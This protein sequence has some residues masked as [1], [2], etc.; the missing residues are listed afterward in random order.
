MLEPFLTDR[1]LTTLCLLAAPL[2]LVLASSKGGDI[3]PEV[4]ALISELARPKLLIPAF[5]YVAVILIVLIPASRLGAW[6]PSLW[7]ATVTWLLVSGFGLLLGLNEAIE[8]PKFFRHAL[9]RIVGVTA[10]F[11]FIAN[12]ESFPLWTEIPAQVLALL[13]AIIVTTRAELRMASARRVARAYL[14][15]LGL[16]AVVW[17]VWHLVDTWSEL[18]HTL[19]AREFLMPV[20]LTP[21]A[22]LLVYVYAVVAAYELAFI[23]MR[24]AEQEKSLWRQRLGLILRG[25]IWL[26]T[27][28]HIRGDGAGRIARTTGFR[29]AWHEA[30]SIRRD[31]RAEAEAVAAAERRLVENAGCLGVDEFGI[32]LD[33][34]EHAETRLALRM[35]AVSQ[36]GHYRNGWQR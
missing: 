18:D 8:D 11:E 2:I 14:A 31:R 13:A 25:G 3:L 23:R 17:A 6:E 20:W 27:L 29:E 4:A 24:G 9:L 32:Q 21:A 28:R 35:L 33:R 30:G 26:P 12:L 5:L 19:L 15:L 22:L 34:R 10:L 36:M 7:K 16:S 1:E